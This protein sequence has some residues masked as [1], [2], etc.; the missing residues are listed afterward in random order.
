[1]GLYQ[2]SPFFFT[3]SLA[4]MSKWICLWAICLTSLIYSIRGRSPQG[5]FLKGK[6]P[7]HPAHG[8]CNLIPM[9]GSATPTLLQLLGEIASRTIR[10][11]NGILL[12]AFNQQQMSMRPLPPWK[13]YSHGATHIQDHVIPSLDR[14]HE[15]CLISLMPIG[16]FTSSPSTLP[17]SL[18]K[19]L[20]ACE[21]SME[22]QES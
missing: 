3:L 12:P 7:R 5:V 8:L 10:G 17:F 1:M 2:H 19:A 21:G 9:L 15:Y 4:S 13:E 14:M 6:P 22:C 20:Q 18:W 11:Y 16:Q